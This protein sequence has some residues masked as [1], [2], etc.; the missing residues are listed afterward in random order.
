MPRVSEDQVLLLW[1]ALH[2][3]RS[4]AKPRCA[5]RGR[6]PASDCPLIGACPRWQGQ[7]DDRLA[8]FSESL[9]ETERRRA[10]WPCSTLLAMLS[11]DVTSIGS[12]RPVMAEESD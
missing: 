2:A 9:E 7:P 10:T 8:S 6:P 12:E 1:R 11:P 3:F 5:P 4:G